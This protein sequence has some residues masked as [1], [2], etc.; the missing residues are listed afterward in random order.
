[1]NTIRKEIG[2]KILE[3]INKMQMQVSYESDVPLSF[4]QQMLDGD[5][6]YYF[7]DDVMYDLID[8]EQSLIELLGEELFYK[9]NCQNYIKSI[10]SLK[11]RVKGYIN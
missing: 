2:D 5:F 9:E 11:A 10:K 7:V 3:F 6:D 8:D 1:M 4:Q